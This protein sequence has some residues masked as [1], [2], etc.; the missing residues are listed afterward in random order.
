MENAGA[1]RGALLLM[2]SDA[3]QVEAQ[4]TSGRAGVA[5]D[6]RRTR[7]CEDE[8]PET[9]IQYAIRTRTSVILDDA[10][11]STLFA[12]DPY[13]Q[14]GRPR[15]MLCLPLVKQ[16]TLVGLLYLENSL[17]PG[18]FTAERVTVLELLAAQAA[19]SL[20]NA[21]LYADLR[22]RE[23]RIRQ[24]VD[25]SIIGV[26]FWNLS[27]KITDANDA[28]LG[29]VGYSRKD[30][31]S[32]QIPWKMMAPGEY[33]LLDMRMIDALRSTRRCPSLEKELVRKDR[34]RVPVLIGAALLEGS[35]DDG[36]AFVLDL[37]ERK[38]AEWEREARRVAEEANR[39]KSEFLATMSH[40]IRTP[41]NAIIGMSQLALGSGLT[42]KQHHYI[43][44]VH[45][46]AQHLLGIINDILDFSKIE[47][48]KLQIEA[49]AFSLGDVMDNLA[50]VVGQQAEEKNLELVFL[51]PPQLPTRLV[52][53]PLRLGQV[54]INLTN[55]AVK[56]TERGEITVSVEVIETDTA[57][58]KLRFGVR[59]TGIGISTEQRHRLFQ[60]FSQGDASTSR[61][62][63][64]TGLG[65][66]ICHH[67]VH[68]MGGAIGVESTP[69]QGSYFTFEARFGLQSSR[70]RIAFSRCTVGYA[71]IGGRRQCRGPSRDRR[72]VPRAR[73]GCRGGGGRRGC[74]ACG[75]ARCRDGA[76]V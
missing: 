1:E 70:P 38:Q 45:R 5:V 29:I 46:S 16:A 30:L 47:A 69:G 37:T 40:E 4:A 50:N 21:R 12:G 67:L 20:E 65:L 7:V 42:A 31:E 11:L 74:V 33:D 10:T 66:A 9:V 22:E 26:F 19:I 51:E 35:R 52:G 18:V 64:G 55:N 13:V 63:G 14:R 44:N 53:D 34:T 15:S 60:A 28:F 59:D 54:L 48:G 71:R 24:L 68:L 8:L 36:V 39:A 41:M 76:S 72:N 62:Y 73:A 3:L 43:D 75:G 2:R 6:L 56:F 49:I 25:S 23:D 17:T 32:Q 58:V 57:A 27:G 61:R